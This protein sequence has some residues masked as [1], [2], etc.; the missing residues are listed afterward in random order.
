MG[1]LSR[2]LARGRVGGGIKGRKERGE[3]GRK[4][5]KTRNEVATNT[6]HGLP[7]RHTAQPTPPTT[8]N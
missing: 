1:D 8:H 2:E 4:A 7:S 3:E 5:R 6:P